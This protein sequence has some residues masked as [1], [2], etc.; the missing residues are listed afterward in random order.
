MEDVLV[1]LRNFPR[2]APADYQLY[3]D[4]ADEIE[5]L[6]DVIVGWCDPENP[7]VVTTDGQLVIVQSLHQQHQ[8]K[9][10]Q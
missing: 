3:E 10:Q 9:R 5:R 2:G 6:R 1:R 8:K 7:P 4:A